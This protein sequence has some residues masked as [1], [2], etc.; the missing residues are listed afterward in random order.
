M[1]LKEGSVIMRKKR[2]KIFLSE[3][4]GS[5]LKEL[6][7][8]MD[9]DI[10]DVHSFDEIMP[11]ALNINPSL[12]IGDFARMGKPVGEICQALK[13]NFMVRHIPFVVVSQN[14]DMSEKI[15]AVESGVSDYILKPFQSEELIAKINRSIKDIRNALNAN[16]LTRLPGNISIEEHLEWMIANQKP[17]A[18]CYFDIDHFKSYND[19]YGYTAGDRILSSTASLILQCREEIQPHSE[20]FFVGHVGGDDFIAICPEN[21]AEKFCK[22]FIARF[23]SMVPMQYDRETAERGFILGRDRKGRVCAFPLVSISIAVVINEGGCKF[24][25]IGEISSAGAEIKKF[26]KS[27]PG[28]SY[29]IDRRNRESRKRNDSLPFF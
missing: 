6:L 2:E 8:Q 27:R 11:K 20:D 4:Q 1:D 3:S 25:H 15:K 22:N 14:G 18:V 12:I 28:S 5:E 26:L 19:L 29:L 13:N 24:E 7:N 9:F 17:M 21:V 23:D 16:P 10:V